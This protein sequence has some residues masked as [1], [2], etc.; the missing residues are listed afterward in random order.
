MSDN[1]RTTHRLPRYALRHPLM[2]ALQSGIVLGLWGAI[3][4]RSILGAMV[5]GLATSAFMLI[6]WMPP[7][8]IARRYTERVIHDGDRSR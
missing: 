4:Y 5:C 6:L 1:D 7:F 2:L 3:L 8:G